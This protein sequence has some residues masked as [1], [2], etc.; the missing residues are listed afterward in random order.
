MSHSMEE[1]Q[2]VA[3]SQPD[4][5][6]GQEQ[7]QCSLTLPDLQLV[8]V[9]YAI[10]EATQAELASVVSGF[11]PVYSGSYRQPGIRPIRS[12][13]LYLVHSISP[14]EVQVFKVEPDGSGDSIIIKREGSVEVLYSPLELTPLHVSMLQHGAF[15]EQ[16][17][18]RVNVGAY[19][20]G[21]GTA[22]LLNPDDLA[23]AL[24]DDVGEHLP[25]P[26]APEH[27]GEQNEL[28][29]G[30]YSW[31]EGEGEDKEWQL[32]AASSITASIAGEYKLDS[33]CLIVEDIT[34]R[35]KDLSQAWACAAEQ[36]GSWHDKYQTEN[37]AARTIDG[38]MNVDFTPHSANA[39]QGNIPEW[40]GDAGSDDQADLR[41]LADLYEQRRERR[42]A[43]HTAHTGVVGSALA[44]INRDIDELSQHIAENLSTD[45]ESVKAF[46][47]QSEQAHFNE[48]I[49]G[50]YALAPNGIV[51]V[52]R[53]QELEDFL[54][55][56]NGLE[57]AWQ[58]AYRGIGQDLA[59]LL[60]VWHNYALLLDREDEVHISF[61]SKL[62]HCA[63]ETLALCGQGDFLSQHYMGNVPTTAH[64]LHF[65]PTDTFIKTFLT[66]LGGPQKALTLAAALM[67]AAGA[68]GNYQTWRSTIEQQVGLRFRSIAGISDE[69]AADIAG[70]VYF[71]EK[72]LG[73]AVIKTLLDDA[74]QLELP[75]RFA[76]LAGMLPEG[77]RLMFVERLGLL[78]MAW[79]IP[80]QTILGKLQQAI[81]KAER[82]LSQ[83]QRLEQEMASYYQ[84]R[85]AQIK[86][87][88]RRGAS[89]AHRRAADQY[90]ANNIRNKASEIKQQQQLISEAL[91][92]LAEHSFPANENG[93]HALKVGGLSQ[94]ATRAALAERTAFKELANQPRDTMRSTLD[95]LVR[96]EQSEVSITRAMGVLVNGSLSVM[97]AITTF[98]AMKDMF[99]R[100]G[101]E[102]ILEH[103]GNTGSQTMAT[104]ASIM[105]IREMIVDARHRKLY[106]GRAFQ[107]VAQAELKAA[108]GSPAQLERWAKVA[109]KA[110]GFV[111][112]LGGVAGAFEML[113]QAQKLGRAETQA[114]RLAT[115]VAL[116]GATGT[117]GGGLFLGSMGLVGKI[118]GAPAAQWRLLMLQ[119]A[120]PVG[121]FVAVST[122]LLVMGDLLASR[123]SLSPVQRWCQRSHWGLRRE[124][125]GLEAHEQALGQLSGSDAS[126]ERQGVA[127]SHAGPGVGPAASDLAF[128]LTMPGG[129]PPD[130]ET[131]S[132][133]LWGVP[134][135]GSHQELTR[136]VLAHAYQE[137]EEAGSVVTYH[138]APEVL[139]Q[140]YFVRLV[141]CSRLNGETSTQ[142]YELHRRGRSLP[143]S[144]REV[145]ALT[146]S[147]FSSSK[148][149]TWPSMPL[150]PWAF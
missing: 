142:V 147:F 53:Q 55:Y 99:N 83:L 75:Q 39:G 94:A 122:L 73:E 89:Q 23:S 149:G 24:A 119:F 87:A 45:A 85:D 93:S 102:D 1:A 43:I 97:G 40:L 133:G 18:M 47:E 82:S 12:G 15:R 22:H 104:A 113:R 56:A 134:M 106:E 115:Q 77:Q 63:M 17:M 60:P 2:R 6:P 86:Q 38:L 19:C 116:V 144:W 50:N 41:E 107:Q 88:S 20:P 132:V 70:E 9:R 44:P 32:A 14:D 3:D 80:D 126:V 48:V 66:E 114:E 30:S 96:N 62:E 36:Q 13:W 49:G 139:S 61:T 46:V 35:L 21:N 67:T 120:G 108:A 124:F 28:D 51:D 143:E 127:V 8:P 31:C 29:M 81:T 138:L 141:V 118:L 34:G 54:A 7:G 64:L 125:Q 146:D 74:Q 105:A 57:E 103:V 76:N 5:D 59:G 129:Q 128:R 65:Q 111:A 33:A 112:G 79:E 16:V 109:N 123:F 78:E 136:D 117:A 110:M 69:V 27:P 10:V 137:V 121:W 90:H 42:E 52:I 25:T 92:D 148:A 58:A 68:L 91:D 95:T 135:S 84:E 98:V 101:Q 26:A 71:K 100:I 72:M 130:E 145:S 140:Y 4:N 11:S 150:I 37:F 131:L